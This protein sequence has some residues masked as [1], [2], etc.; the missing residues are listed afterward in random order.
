MSSIENCIFIAFVGVW[1]CRS[2]LDFQD[3]MNF[4]VSPRKSRA[5]WNDVKFF[6]SIRVSSK[7]PSQAG[8]QLK[9]WIIDE[10][11]T[12]ISQYDSKTYTIEGFRPKT[13]G[14]EVTTTAYH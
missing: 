13:T 8:H 6:N 2:R 5:S 7:E 10:K 4:V 3:K 12:E 11:T 1:Q 14:S 9:T